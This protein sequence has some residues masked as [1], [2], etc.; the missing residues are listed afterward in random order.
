MFLSPYQQASHLAGMIG[1][2]TGA[3][4]DENDSR[5]AQMREAGRQEHEYRLQMDALLARLQ[6]ER[7]MAERMMQYRREQDDKAR[8]V[9]FSSEW[10]KPIPYR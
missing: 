1:Q 4:Q 9:L 10:S 3:I 8:G 6:H 2:T 7:Y 5:V